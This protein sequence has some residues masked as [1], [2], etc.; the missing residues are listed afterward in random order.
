MSVKDILSPVFEARRKVQNYFEMPPSSIPIMPQEL[1]VKTGLKSWFWASLALGLGPYVLLMGPAM[2][3]DAEHWFAQGRWW[4]NLSLP[5]MT[6]YIL[7]LQPIFRRFL[8]NLI[9]IFLP[10]LPATRDTEQ[11]MAE[12]YV[13]HR[14]REWL[15]FGLGVGVGWFIGR[16]WELTNLLLIL[17]GFLGEGLLFGLL[18]WFVYSIL[19]STRLLTTLYEQTRAGNPLQSGAFTPLTRW[20]IGVGAAI[21]GGIALSTIFVGKTLLLSP[22]NLIVYGILLLGVM[23]IFLWSVVSASLLSQFR[24]VRA[25][26]L[27]FVVALLGTLGYQRI[28]GWELLDGLYMTIITMTTIGYGEISP[29]SS[30][31]RIYTILLSLISIGIGGYAISALAAFIVEGDFNQIIHRRKMEREI[32]KLND[33]IILCGAG[34]V[35]LQVAIEFYKTR[36]PFVLLEQDMAALEAVQ[37]IGDIL[38]IQGNATKDEILRLAGV[39]RAKGLVVA[40][41]DDK[42]NAFVVL[43]ARSLNPKLRIIARLTDEENAEKLR[44]VGADEIVST[45]IIGGLRIASVMIRPSVVTFLDEMLRVTGQTLRMEELHVKEAS[46]LVGKTLGQVDIGRQTGLLVV[47]IKSGER[48]YQFN[49]GGQTVLQNGDILIVIGTPEQLIPLRRMGLV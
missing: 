12:A 1:L 43:S 10:L 14:G 11:L 35:G 26:L 31:G 30:T 21:I 42:D 20:S 13:L 34:R 36:T 8:R 40:F 37:R 29:L 32:T 3:G 44:K 25:L 45:N 27:F 47:A 41:S 22:I 49:P 33:H 24:V 39:E 15:A 9:E 19:T 18:G 5:A 16:P 6:I 7:L 23:L 38:Y 2:L 4:I 28:E 48:G 17:Y 46:D